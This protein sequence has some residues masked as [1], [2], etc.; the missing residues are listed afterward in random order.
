MQKPTAIAI[1]KSNPELD[2]E[3]YNDTNELIERFRRSISL[4]LTERY[5]DEDELID[6]F[7]SAGDMEDDLLRLEVLN[8]ASRFHPESDALNQRRG[9][10]YSLI[11]D[12][13]GAQFLDLHA[14]SDNPMWRILQLRQKRKMV[15]LDLTKELDELLASVKQ[16]DDDEV[17][18][19]FIRLV[20]ELNLPQWLMDNI[21]TILKRTP[22]QKVVLFEGATAYEKML[23]YEEA[24]ALLVRL[25]DIDPFGAGNWLM[26]AEQY[27]MLGNGPEFLNAIDYALALNPD[28]WQALFIK[29]KY[30]YSTE[31]YATARD[32]LS[33]ACDADLPMLDPYRLYVY[34]LSA[35]GESEK[36]EAICRKLLTLFPDAVSEIIPDLLSFSPADASELFTIFYRNNP[37]NTEPFWRTWCNQLWELGLKTMAVTCANSFFELTGQR[38]STMVV[39]EY[40]FRLNTKHEE[41]IAWLEDYRR[42]REDANMDLGTY[43][44]I[45]AITQA[46]M[47]MFSLAMS[48]CMEFINR[49]EQPNDF[50]LSHSLSYKYAQ[51]VIKLVIARLMFYFDPADYADL[52]V[53]DL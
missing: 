9:L 45:V 32:L 49:R 2:E 46:R 24:A 18:I 43:Y 20:A 5:F 6:I 31:D 33:K 16:F 3:Q 35:L 28:D 44:I 12:T 21:E 8:V 11:S 27:L 42:V 14:A 15:H 17:A 29:A 50:S 47:G 26:L 36:A 30:A 52:S 34:T 40:Y 39:A 38:V 10:F 1:S 25:T 22:H 4:P 53:F 19:Q 41:T 37:E 23:Q 13:A 48:Y 51:H 7:D